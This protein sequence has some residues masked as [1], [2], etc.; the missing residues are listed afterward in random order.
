MENYNSTLAYY[1]TSL[2]AN[3]TYDDEGNDWSNKTDVESDSITDD[4]ITAAVLFGLIIILGISGNSLVV[5]VMRKYAEKNATNCYIINL[6]F[7]DLIFV[8][9]VVPFTMMHYVIPQWLFG[10]LLCKLSQYMI[11][12]STLASIHIVVYVS[13]ILYCSIY[14]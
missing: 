4:M 7:T 14:T 12:V 3:L 10:E 9:I 5:H 1:D 8:I 11:Y 13:T 6:A 2:F